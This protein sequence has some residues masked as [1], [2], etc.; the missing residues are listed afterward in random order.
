MTIYIKEVKEFSYLNAV[1]ILFRE[2]DDSLAFDLSF[3]E[4]EKELESLPGRY[5][6]LALFLHSQNFHKTVLLATLWI[7]FFILK[8]FKVVAY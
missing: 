6:V 2:Y 1:C 8:F 5:T 3:Q 7:M 4:F